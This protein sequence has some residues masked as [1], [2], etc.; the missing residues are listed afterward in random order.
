MQPDNGQHIITETAYGVL[1]G[2]AC[3]LANAW[4]IYKQH[5]NWLPGEIEVLAHMLEMPD[6]SLVP[7]AA[8]RVTEALAELL[9]TKPADPVPKL[10]SLLYGPA[11]R[12]GEDTR[13]EV[14]ATE[15]DQQDV[16]L[17]LFRH[18]LPNPPAFEL[19][20]AM[21]KLHPER[22]LAL[23]EPFAQRLG[24]TPY[25]VQEAAYLEAARELLALPA[26]R[27]KPEAPEHRVV[28]RILEFVSTWLVDR[29]D[30]KY[31][32]ATLAA[33]FK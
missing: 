12:A 27:W 3:T 16:V 1:T 22:E 24:K 25:Y 2:Y 30:Y 8:Q 14:L 4:A 7:V 21:E 9:K 29:T 15:K 11:P 23:L 20:A 31:G 17:W 5:Q 10:R 18:G 13:I 33:E 19:T 26:N 28:S 6:A 32:V